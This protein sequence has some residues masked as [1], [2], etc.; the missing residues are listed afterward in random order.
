[1]LIFKPSN[2]TWANKPYEMGQGVNPR[3]AQGLCHGVHGKKEHMPLT[4]KKEP[5]QH[6]IIRYQ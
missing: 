5:Q 3:A 6:C 4:I 2:F 1:L